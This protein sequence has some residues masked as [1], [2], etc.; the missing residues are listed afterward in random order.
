MFNEN[1]YNLKCNIIIINS[2]LLLVKE[3]LE[4]KLHQK[5]NSVHTCYV[6]HT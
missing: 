2:D 6:I 5:Q 3:I 1:Y 4:M